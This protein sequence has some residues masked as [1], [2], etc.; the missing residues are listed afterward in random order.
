VLADDDFRIHAKI[1]GAAENFD[2]AANGPCAVASVANEFRVDDRAV[3]FGNVRESRALAG[4]IF[5]AGEQLLTESGIK[6]FVPLPV[7]VAGATLLSLA[8]ALLAKAALL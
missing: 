1:A 7:I 8:E 6:F 3:E 4:A 2:D 5:F